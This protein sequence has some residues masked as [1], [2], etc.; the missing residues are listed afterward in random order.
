M[1]WLKDMTPIVS[2]YNLYLY[3]K[4]NEPCEC[5]IPTLG[6]RINAHFILPQIWELFCNTYIFPKE[7]RYQFLSMSYIK[8][9]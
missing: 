9:M 5:S 6:T 1:N 7:I 2:K 4:F 8:I 3:T